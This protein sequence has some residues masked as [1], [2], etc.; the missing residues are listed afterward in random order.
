[1]FL[2]S[3]AAKYARTAMCVLGSRLLEEGSW[4]PGIVD[5]ANPFTGRVQ[6]KT[7]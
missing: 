1:M 5:H 6:A 4:T 7:G 3:A 2:F